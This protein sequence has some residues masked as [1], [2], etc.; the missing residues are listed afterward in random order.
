MG[1]RL[2]NSLKRLIKAI[3]THKKILIA[4]HIDPDCDGICSALLMTHFVNHFQKTKPYLFCHSPLPEKYQFLS[5]NY[6]FSKSIKHFD[7]LIA[8]DSADIDR[9]FPKEKYNLNFLNGKFII[10]IDHHRS[11]KQFGNI[12]I[13]DEKASSACEIIYGLFK[14]LNI[15][16]ERR[17]AE[18][19]YAGIYNETGGFVYPNTTSAA[20]RICS[21]LINLGIEPSVLVKKLNAKTIA[22]TKLLSAVLA[23]IEIKNGIGTM[24]LTQKM[25][26]KYRARISESENFISF[27]QAIQGVRISVFFREEKDSI[28]ISLRSDGLL[29]VNNFARRFGGGG[30]RLAAGIRLKDNLSLAKKKILSALFKELI[31]AG[32]IQ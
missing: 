31:N 14:K 25:L 8:V 16:I 28:R 4:T 5:K 13:I 24:Y 11:N 29:D 12:A 1:K 10:N 30:H 26:N 17:I 21:D 3:K 6:T 27:L 23:T 7:L 2:I 20:L 15:K 32:H 19:F 22:G 18:I 9:I